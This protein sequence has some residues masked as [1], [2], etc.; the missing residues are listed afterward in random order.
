MTRLIIATLTL[1]AGPLAHADW[2]SYTEVPVQNEVHECSK[3]RKTPADYMK[4]FD[5]LT[6]PYTK[7]NEIRDKSGGLAAITLDKG[8]PGTVNEEVRYMYKDEKTC[9]A[10]QKKSAAAAKSKNDKANSEAN[11]KYEEYK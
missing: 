7:S 2:F 6:I 4:F 11:K 9:V 5:E 8:T 1:F 10:A 3:D